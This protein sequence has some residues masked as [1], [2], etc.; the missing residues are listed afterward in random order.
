MQRYN[1]NDGSTITKENQNLIIPARVYLNNLQEYINNTLIQFVP[2]T[3]ENKL[4]IV[5][6]NGVYLTL[7]DEI[8]YKPICNLLEVKFHKEDK[9][10]Q[11]QYYHTLFGS[12]L[13]ELNC[14]KSEEDLIIKFP[15]I[16]SLYTKRKELITKALEIYSVTNRVI[17]SELANST[18]SKYFA[19]YK[20]NE[21]LYNQLLRESAIFNVSY[22]VSCVSNDITNL[23]NSLPMFINSVSL[24]IIDI[25]SIPN[26]DTKKVS[27]LIS[28]ENKLKR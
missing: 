17:P 23:V 14:I 28:E 1:I 26:I 20:L 9:N 16:Y 10:Q 2:F 15:Y 3:L 21:A 4:E 8:I 11:L 7:D 27:A 5:V 18:K 12:K 6:E 25:N 22:F 13:I 24:F 19:Q